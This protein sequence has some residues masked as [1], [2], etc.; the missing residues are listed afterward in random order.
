MI[1]IEHRPAGSPPV[2][3]F[4]LLVFRTLKGKNRG[5]Q[6]PA[7][8]ARSIRHWRYC[9]FP[10]LCIRSTCIINPPPSRPPCTTAISFG[11]PDVSCAL[12]TQQPGSGVSHN[13][14]DAAAH[15]WT[16]T[17]P[18]CH[19]LGVLWVVPAGVGVVSSTFYIKTAH[20]LV[21]VSSGSRCRC[22]TN[23]PCA[24]EA[25]LGLFPGAST[26]AARP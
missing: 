9:M 17:G 5:G 21:P 3:G 4:R 23:W 25:I 26:P 1:R 14:A 8:Q 11:S 20:C 22:R 13:S 16:T 12:G 7:D 15:Y 6:R 24:P 2:W 10:S 18:P 19:F